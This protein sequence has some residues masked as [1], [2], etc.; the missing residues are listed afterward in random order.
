MSVRRF[1]TPEEAE[2]AYYRAFQEAD[3]DLMMSLWLE[4]DDIVCVHPVRGT[5][6]Q[7]Q[8]AVLEGWLN[9]FARELD[10]RIALKNVQ[11][12]RQ[13]EVAIRSGEEHVVRLGDPRVRG[14]N[15]F[16]N[17]YVETPQGWRL[18]VHHASPGPEAASVDPELVAATGDGGSHMH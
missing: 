3:L 17:V 4:R 2:A 16:T 18:L 8:A 10:I 13:G 14:V 1:Q 7:G 9:V 15:N 11:Q 6:L 5:R 12:I